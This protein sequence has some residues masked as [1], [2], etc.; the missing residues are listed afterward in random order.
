MCAA[1]VTVTVVLVI[2][3]SVLVLLDSCSHDLLL[4]KEER[5]HIGT[6]PNATEH[7][8]NKMK[9]RNEH[10]M[11]KVKRSSAKKGCLP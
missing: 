4:V 2:L 10:K 9:T 1:G 7:K 6:I 11:H 3:L 8:K 5:E